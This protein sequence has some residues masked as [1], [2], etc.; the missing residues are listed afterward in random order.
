MLNT[1]SYLDTKILDIDP[2][3]IPF[4]LGRAYAHRFCD[5]IL[6]YGGA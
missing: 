1:E 4:L 2:G 3:V 6:R 5:L